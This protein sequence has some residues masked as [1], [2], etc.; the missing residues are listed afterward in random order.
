[1]VAGDRRILTDANNVL[2]RDIDATA[3]PRRR[4]SLGAGD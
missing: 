3:L 1:V 2:M 4:N